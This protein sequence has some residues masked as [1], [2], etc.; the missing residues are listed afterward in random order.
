M[1]RRGTTSRHLLLAVPPEADVILAKVGDPDALLW[2]HRDSRDLSV[3]EPLSMTARLMCL[4]CR[5]ELPTRLDVHQVNGRAPF[6][7]AC[8]ESAKG[9]PF[10]QWLD[11]QW[12]RQNDDAR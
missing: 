4:G 7:F 6:C 9:R 1:S 8:A 2:D 12:Q 10:D 11:E 3:S 5:R